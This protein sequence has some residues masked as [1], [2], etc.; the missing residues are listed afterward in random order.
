[1]TEAATAP[2]VPVRR[3]VLVVGLGR[4][5]TSLFTS[6]LGRLGFHLP[7]PQVRP[8]ETNPVGFGEPRW[9]VDFHTRLMRARRVTVFDS[10]PQ[11]WEATADAAGDDG[12]FAEL[13]S[14]LAVQFV[15]A[16]NVAVK[17]PRIAWFLPLW[18]RCADDLGVQTSFA[19]M[20]RHPAEV[21][22]SARKS[23][24]TWQNDASRTASWLNI[25]LQT[26]HATRGAAR[27]FLRYEALLEDWS[28]EISRCGEQLDLP[29]L[30]GIDRSG[31]PDVEA[32]VDPSLRRA[33]VGWDDLPIPAPLRALT[34]EVWR[35]LGT[36]ADRDGDDRAARASLDA[37]RE[38][39]T[40]LYGEAEAIA[41]SSITAVRPRR[42]RA[43]PPAGR[44]RRERPHAPLRVRALRLL[45][46][47]YRDRVRFAVRR[48]ILDTGRDLPLPVRIGLLI[49][50]RLRERIPLPV[51]RAGYRVARGLRR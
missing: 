32:L 14:W 31:H 6:I 3:L 20:L 8:D 17:D 28:R 49:P 45:P 12:V 37:A 15:G 43:G 1:M 29:S 44:A 2:P 16:E 42:G 21:V 33:V 34:D 24:G 36:L 4:A 19:T 13:R 41:Q 18:R 47:P 35:H 38:E 48:R 30:V 11:A 27:A 7:H 23:Y 9:V 50:P 46:R 26:E 22:A 5:G 51:L 40:R 39:Y 10:R 25:M